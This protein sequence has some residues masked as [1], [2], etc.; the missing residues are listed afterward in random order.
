MALRDMWVFDY[1]PSTYTALGLNETGWALSYTNYGLKPDNYNAQY[2][3]LMIW[4]NSLCTAINPGAPRTIRVSA[5]ITGLTDGT[6]VKSHLSF[7]FIRINTT[8]GNLTD[9]PFMWLDDLVLLTHSD[10]ITAVLDVPLKIDLTFDRV[11]KVIYL[12]IA[13][14]LKRKINAANLVDK[15]KPGTILYMGNLSFVGNSGWW[16]YRDFVFI[17]DTQDDTICDRPLDHQVSSMV[18]SAAVN[19]GWG[20][21]V[22]YTALSALNTAITA[23]ANLNTPVLKAQADGDS[24]D[25]S[26]TSSP[27]AGMTL[28]AV[29]L[30]TSTNL[31]SGPAYNLGVKISNDAGSVDGVQINRTGVGWQYSGRFGIYSKAPGNVPWYKT[32]MSKTKFSVKVTMP[33]S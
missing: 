5:P 12:Y 7:K 11:N 3:T 27:P 6:S 14:K 24:V 20:I 1:L 19:A 33:S 13:D 17:D 4:N 28:R 8:G 25:I 9:V 2:T 15:Y 22:G 29:G 26:Y 21:T 16:C 18:A 30:L 31:V 23:T 32:D 10:T